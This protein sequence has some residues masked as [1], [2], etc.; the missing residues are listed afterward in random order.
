MAT[1]VARVQRDGAR[2]LDILV[3]WR[4]TASWF[5]SG[6]GGGSGSSGGG[7][8]R[9]YHTTISRGDVQLQLEF[10]SQTR[11]ATITQALF[12]SPTGKATIQK[13][14]IELRDRNV[15]LVDAVDDANGP[16]IVGT[17][18]IEPVLPPGD[19]PAWV[20]EALRRSPEI[21]SF[22]RCDTRLDDPLKQKLGEII[23]ASV[24]GQ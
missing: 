6:S 18:R 24:L 3:L 15:L 7:D 16:Q 20:G 9:L 23:C 14:Q 13:R 22:L 21:V 1:W 2:E 11:L 10:D 17:Q 19:S 8:C 12:R 4:G 5:A